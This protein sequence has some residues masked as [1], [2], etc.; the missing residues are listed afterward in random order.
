[1]ELWEKARH[2]A[3]LTSD[4]TKVC[5]GKHTFLVRTPTRFQRSLAEEI[6]YETLYSAFDAYSEA[7][8]SIMLEERMIWTPADAER[9]DKINKDIEKLKILLFEN[10]LRYT[11]LSNIRNGLEKSKEEATR[12][13]ILKHSHDYLLRLNI[14]QGAKDRYLLG[15][16]LYSLE[17]EPYWDQDEG[18]DT[19]DPFLT[20]VIVQ[21]NKQSL[22]QEDLREIARTEPWSG[23]WE[24]QKHCER[25]FKVSPIELNDDQRT[26][27]IWS[28]IY[29]SV[30]EHPDNLQNSVIEDDD[31]IDGWMIL[32]RR[33]RETT[34]VKDE[35]LTKNPKIKGATEQFYMR[36]PGSV[37]PNAKFNSIEEVNEFMKTANDEST[38]SIIKQRTDV[39]REKGEVKEAALPDVAMKNRMA[40]NKAVA[41][42]TSKLGKH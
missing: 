9:L 5:V 8:L 30:R 18:W 19:P 13:T 7:D 42:R 23:L 2:I 28:S 36:P 25:I 10:R 12:M 11:S 24:M 1:M 22:S 17:G 41:E 29:S 20:Q 31:M 38:L 4:Q 40:Y 34:H 35:G 39:I 26:L 21:I 6:Y 33:E 37:D 16:S 3:R 15:C 32:K 27:I 14:A